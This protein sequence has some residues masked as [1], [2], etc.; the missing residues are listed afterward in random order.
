[1]SS[2]GEMKMSLKLMTCCRVRG[3]QFAASGLLTFS[4]FR[5]F[6]SF[7]SRYVRLES[8]GVLNGFII[9]LIATAWLVSWSL[10]ELRGC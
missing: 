2:S 4:C 1:M 7:S 6:R 9:F 5:C 3:A 10:A 8:T